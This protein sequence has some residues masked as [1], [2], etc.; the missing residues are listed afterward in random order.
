[1]IDFLSPMIKSNSW[2]KR[3]TDEKIKLIKNDQ[4]FSFH[5]QFTKYFKMVHYS[6]TN[7]QAMIGKEAYKAVWKMLKK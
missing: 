6:Y 2:L 1:M 5:H 7:E 4:P 3:N